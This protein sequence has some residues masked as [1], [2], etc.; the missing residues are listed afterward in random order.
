M[1]FAVAGIIAVVAI[2]RPGRDR[3]EWRLTADN[4]ADAI[5]IVTDMVKPDADVS[6]LVAVP[7]FVEV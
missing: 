6:M 3:V 2:D 5:R 7:R 4:E 1:N